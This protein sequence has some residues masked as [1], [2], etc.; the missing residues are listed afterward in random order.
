MTRCPG[1]RRLIE[2]F[3]Y[4]PDARSWVHY[5]FCPRCRRLLQH[6]AA[7]PPDEEISVR[8]LRHAGPGDAQDGTAPSMP[9]SARHWCPT[10]SVRVET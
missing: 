3:P 6:R 1:C 5:G 9:R 2:L 4:E 7:R 8:L 10:R